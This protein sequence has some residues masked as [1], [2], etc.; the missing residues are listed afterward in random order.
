MSF[1]FVQT[2]LQ[3]LCKSWKY[4]TSEDGTECMCSILR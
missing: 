3:V 1:R 2:Q 4:V